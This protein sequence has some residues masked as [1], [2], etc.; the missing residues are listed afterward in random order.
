MRFVILGAGALGSII[1][2]HLARAGEDVMVIARG[3]R[4]RLRAAAR[5]HHHRRGR[6]HHRL[7]G[8]HRPCGTP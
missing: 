5:D 8:D 4:A 3:D 2:G 1:A 6:L 7:P